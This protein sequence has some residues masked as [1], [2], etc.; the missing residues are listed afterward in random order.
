MTRA[1]SYLDTPLTP[2]D[3]STH[4]QRQAF[5]EPRLRTSNL[6][7]QNWHAYNLSCMIRIASDT[8]TMTLRKTFLLHLSLMTRS[9]CL[10]IKL[11]DQIL[12]EDKH[13]P[14]FKVNF[15]A[16]STEQLEDPCGCLQA[17]LLDLSHLSCL[18]LLPLAGACGQERRAVRSWWSHAELHSRS[19]VAAAGPRRHILLWVCRR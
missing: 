19:A 16:S 12:A 9:C 15:L 5:L 17:K 18:V 14:L 6:T 11:A 10:Q 1:D 2:D 13:Q 4:D 8:V 7:S 3:S